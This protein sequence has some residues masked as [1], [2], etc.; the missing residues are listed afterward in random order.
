MSGDKTTSGNGNLNRAQIDAKPK[1]GTSGSKDNSECA[2]LRLGNLPRSEA[3]REIDR[4]K[5]AGAAV[6]AAAQQNSSL[7]PN[8]ESVQ[9]VVPSGAKHQSTTSSGN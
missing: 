2:T 8:G 7:L 5:N 4:D 3:V 1:Q 9:N 6:K